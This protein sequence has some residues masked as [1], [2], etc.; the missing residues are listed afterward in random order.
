MCQNPT[1]VKCN[2][3]FGFFFVG[4]KFSVGNCELPKVSFLEGLAEVTP[5]F[6]GDYFQFRRQ[7]KTTLTI[8]LAGQYEGYTFPADSKAVLVANHKKPLNLGN[9]LALN[10]CTASVP[11]YNGDAECVCKPCDDGKIGISVNCAAVKL[12]DNTDSEDIFYPDTTGECFS[13]S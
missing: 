13:L 1:T 7:S 3:G 2:A 9:P 8:G 6:S 4:V 12:I 5:V 10:S 11:S